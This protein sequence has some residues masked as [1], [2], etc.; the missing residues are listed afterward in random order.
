MNQ[1]F[2]NSNSSGFD[3]IQAPQFPVIH[4][5]PQETSEK[6]LQAKEDLMISIET[7][8]KKF[9]RVS[10]RETLTV[11]MQAWDKFFEVKHAQSE[12]VQELLSKLVQDLQSKNRSSEYINITPSWNFPTSSYDDDDDEEEIDIFLGSYDSIPQGIESDVFRTRKM[13]EKNLPSRNILPEFESNSMLI[14]PNSGYSPL[15]WWWKDIP[16]DDFPDF[17]ASRARGFVLRS[18]ELQ[19]ISFIMGI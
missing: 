18:P 8:L 16:V 2:H 12:E 3:Q 13:D 15:D 10:F 7:F 6:I 11:L 5:P 1:N 9:N 19:I 17:E 4:Q 14:L